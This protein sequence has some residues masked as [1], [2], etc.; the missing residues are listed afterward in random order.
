MRLSY[1]KERPSVTAALF[2][3]LLF[4]VLA[5]VVWSA[6]SYKKD[7]VERYETA[8]VNLYKELLGVKAERSLVA[9]SM[10]ATALEE[11]YRDS[12]NNAPVDFDYVL[13]GALSGQAAVYSVA[14]IDGA[15]A[16]IASSTRVSKK[17][18][19]DWALLQYQMGQSSVSSHGH[20]DSGLKT[21]L[22]DV[23][24]GNTVHSLTPFSARNGQAMSLPLVRRI[25]FD[26]R[27]DVYV[28]A[29]VNLD[30]L[31]KEFETTN[32]IEGVGTFIVSADRKVIVSSEPTEVKV[33]LVLERDS[34]SQLLLASDTA[35]ITPTAASADSS[36]GS[37]RQLGQWP[38]FVLVEHSGVSASTYNSREA[39]LIYGAA[40]IVWAVLVGSGLILRNRAARTA[41][42]KSEVRRSKVLASGLAVQRDA[43]LQASLDA[44]FTI[45]A[46][47]KIINL[48]LI[49][50]SM[51]DKPERGALH[52]NF[53]QL[54]LPKSVRDSDVLGIRSYLAK[55]NAALPLMR[56]ELS[57][58]DVNGNE[59]PAEVS[60]TPILL[61]NDKC[62][63]IT[64]RDISARVRSERELRKAED[65]WRF[66]LEASGEGVCDWNVETDAI[67][68][69]KQ[70]QAMFGYE[71]GDVPLTYFAWKKL[72]YPEDL[73]LAQAQFLKHFKGQSEGYMAEYRVL[74]KD[75]SWKW[76]QG[77][78]L[79]V[80]R[81]RQNGR[82]TRFVVT[83]TDISARKR[84][85]IER[86]V[87]LERSLELSASLVEAKES[88]VRLGRSIQ[89]SLLTSS[90]AFP[91]H[92]AWVS[93]FN[94]PSQGVDGDFF[95]VISP[96]ADCVDII[97]GDVMGKGFS[98]ALMGAGIKMELLKSVMDL[99]VASQDSR[100]LPEPVAIIGSL[101]TAI[102]L[103][104]SNLEAFVTL[105]YFRINKKLNTLTWVGCG[106]EEAMLVRNG[107]VIA[108]LP[109]Q[110]P[111]IGAGFTGTLKQDVIAFQINDAL[112]LHSDGA[113][114][115]VDAD[116]SRVGNLRIQKELEALTLCQRTPSVV[117]HS[118]RQAL[119]S[120]R[121]GARQL[122]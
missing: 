18:K 120:L 82:A 71:D 79:V 33:G 62:F 110:Q 53:E 114:D 83:Q 101:Q 102:D 39:Q 56:M 112:F 115:A 113:S 52:Q 75:G 55:P 96:N 92:G 111:P 54:I 7:I 45:D 122:Q 66:A 14:I 40:F 21:W 67:L 94:Q 68:I 63:S 47:G 81:N 107:E 6:L 10:L 118:M 74:C 51:F 80:E 19:I 4:L 59:F 93:A 88:E 2:A 99:I 25:S 32:R 23:R 64:L 108:S 69:S 116:G 106:H 11:S 109:N 41:V 119:Q 42:L 1:F 86:A 70:W 104:L 95:D 58:L 61:A 5:I 27:A 29:L 38:L 17:N 78:G 72:V 49:A 76:V 98:A 105:C 46:A 34:G 90:R 3:S 24:S 117:I 84:H 73:L 35:I 15:G 121:H 20:L 30:F 77:R 103:K 43:V 91:A 26:K 36:I 89:S 100:Q 8:R 50:A 48:N 9:A 31:T 16:V 57:A 87:V 65:R 44:I 22:S 28:V 13:S 85:E 12:N 37:M 60:V 97:I